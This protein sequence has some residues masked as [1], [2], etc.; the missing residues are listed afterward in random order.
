MEYTKKTDFSQGNQN[1]VWSIKI[2]NLWKAVLI[3]PLYRYL[4]SGKFP[5]PLLKVIPST[6]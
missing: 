3:I 6:P 1:P 4:F 2:V 5:F